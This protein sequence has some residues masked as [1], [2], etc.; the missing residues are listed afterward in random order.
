MAGTSAHQRVAPVTPALSPERLAL[1]HDILRLYQCKP[2]PERFR[3]YAHAAVFEDPLSYGRGLAEI[4]AIFYGLALIM[5]QSTT[6]EHSIVCNT[7]DELR[8]ELVQRYTLRWLNVTRVLPSTVVLRFAATFPNQPR[9][10]VVLHQDLWRGKPL[11]N[12]THSTAAWLYLDQG[13]A[14]GYDVM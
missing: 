12:P 14:G 6:L 1:V 2:S 3:H 11:P 10:Q 9:N 4:K 8:M 5:A 7:P 13:I